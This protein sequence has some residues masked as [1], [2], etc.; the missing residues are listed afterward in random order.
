MKK[1]IIISIICFA[2][3]ISTVSALAGTNPIDVNT[4]KENVQKF[5]NTPL[6]Q[7]QYQESKYLDL[8]DYYVFS[9]GDGQAY[10]NM[11][12]GVVERASFTEALESSGNIR[13]D[14]A[15]AKAIASKYAEE[16]YVA[17]SDMNMQLIGSG[18]KNHGDAG[19]EYSFIWRE[20]IKDALTPNMVVVNLNP[21]SGKIISYIGI[22]REITCT[23]E[24]GISHDKAIKIAEEQFPGIKV[25]ESSAEQSIEYTKPGIQSLTWVIT[26][27]G[28][29]KDH[30]L[31]GGLVVIDALTGKVIMTAP[32]L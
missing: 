10:V 5:V 21:D 20:K 15:Q 16:K 17:F 2:L 7:I 25:F 9:T 14:S 31:Q 26:L 27:K 29:P 6:I 4:A 8:G 13:F 23:S 28:E 24:S 22:Q 19:S 18:L 12:T 11:Y 1:I 3:M 30:V 32:Y